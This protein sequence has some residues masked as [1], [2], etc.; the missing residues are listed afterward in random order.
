MDFLYPVFMMGVS[1]EE[2]EVISNSVYG[3]G[4]LVA[5]GVPKTVM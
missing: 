1:S 2:D 4:V 3:L 5:H